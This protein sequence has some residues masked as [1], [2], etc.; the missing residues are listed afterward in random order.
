ME[1]SVEVDASAGASATDAVVDETVA[2]VGAVCFKIAWHGGGGGG[3]LALR[4]FISD[5]FVSLRGGRK[6]GL[7]SPISS[8]LRWFMGIMAEVFNDEMARDD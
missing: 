6:E 7:L 2:D 3:F 4:S 5:V 8:S 1:A